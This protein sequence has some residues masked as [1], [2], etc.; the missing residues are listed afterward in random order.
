MGDTSPN[1]RSALQFFNSLDRSRH[2]PLIPRRNA[3]NF[4][5][6]LKLIVD[7]ATVTSSSY[8]VKKFIPRA[9]LIKV[10]EFVKNKFKSISSQDYTKLPDGDVRE[11]TGVKP[12]VPPRPSKLR[13]QPD[14][15]QVVG[16]SSDNQLLDGY[17]DPKDQLTP[18]IEAKQ[19]FEAFKKEVSPYNTFEIPVDALDSDFFKQTLTI[20]GPTA[21]TGK[22]IRTSSVKSQTSTYRIPDQVKRSDAFLEPYLQGLSDRHSP[23][24]IAAPSPSP[25]LCRGAIPHPVASL[26]G[27]VSRESL[28]SSH[29]GGSDASSEGSEE[30]YGATCDIS[31]M[32]RLV[33]SHPIWFLPGIQRAGAFHLLQGKEEGCF[34]VRKSSQS[35]TMAL[36]VRLPPDKGPY[37]EHYLIHSS[38]GRLGLETSENRFVD[39]AALIAHYSS[40]CDELPVQLALPKTIRESKSRQQLSSLA[41]LGQEFWRY[42]PPPSTASSPDADL[43]LNLNPLMTTFKQAEPSTPMQSKPARPNTL[44]LLNKNDPKSEI[45]R[46]M[47]SLKGELVSKT[48]PPPPPRWSKPSTPQQNNFTVT[49]TVTFSVNSQSPNNEKP[50]PSKSEAEA[51]QGDSK[52]ISPQGQ[53]NSTISSRGGIRHQVMSPNSV[54]SPSS[55]VLSPDTLS[56]LSVSKGTRQSKRTKQKISKHYQESDIVDSPTMHYYKSGLGD[57]ISDYEDVWTNEG[58]LINAKNANPN[59]ASPD[60]LQHTPAN[61]TTRHIVSLNNN[62][63]SPTDSS[64]NGSSHRSVCSTPIQNNLNKASLVQLPLADTN[65]SQQASELPSPHTPKQ[66]SPFYAEP[67]DSLSSINQIPNIPRRQIARPAPG[68]PTQHRH[69]NPPALSSAKVLSTG[70]ERVDDSGMMSSSVDNLSPK[71]RFMGL[72]KPEVKPV[73]PPLIRPMINNNESWQID[74]SWKFVTADCDIPQE[75]TEP[76]YDSDWPTIPNLLTSLETCTPDPDER[77]TLQDLISKRFPDIR[78]SALGMEDDR[79]RISAYDNVEDRRPPRAPP[80]EISELTEFSE[81]WAEIC[82]GTTETDESY[83]ENLTPTSIKVSSLNK[84]K[85]F[86][87]RLDPLLSAPRVEALRNREP[88]GPKTVGLAIRTYAL[89]LAQDKS[90]TFAQ[91]V[92]NFIACTC[93]SKETNPQVVMRNMRQFMN[94]MKNYL[95]KHGEKGFYKEIE[96]ERN[97]LKSTEFLNLDSILEGVMHKL[98]VKPLRNHLQKLFLDHYTKTGAIKL[99]ADNIQYASTRPIHELAIKAKLALPPENVLNKIS[100]YLHKLQQADSPLEKLE[101]LLAAIALIFNTVKSNHQIGSGRSFHLGADDFL[102]LFVWVLVKTNFVAAEIESEYMWGLLHP[103]LLSGEGGYYLTTLSSAV[104]VLKNFKEGCQENVN[105]HVKNESV[106]K[107]VVPD[108]LHGSILTKTLPARPHMTTKEVCKIIAHKARIT[109]PQDY[110]L[111]RL[112]DGEETILL[113]NECPQDFIKEGRHTM[114]A[115]KRIDAKI[116]WPTQDK[117][118]I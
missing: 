105:S 1:F 13:L 38:E 32:E 63:L 61:D 27:S 49:T 33:L 19:I 87:D 40:C 22:S 55:D 111:Y 112:T 14:V 30:G 114:L 70:L 15:V 69:S 57:K 45:T 72:R 82:Q 78:A 76:D 12:K 95:V 84:S 46:S 115:Y 67:A 90:T 51:T 89:E 42:S 103:S 21:D 68:I 47:S 71:Q 52:R 107:V 118:N 16:N 23:P 65:A 7:N 66:Q 62:V 86:R 39:M 108:E 117:L 60:L 96:R 77:T 48:P 11:Q 83:S 34:V 64:H 99:L 2:S 92:D 102:P 3:S 28:V 56:P 94:G 91:N 37:I 74:N 116:A 26:S 54:L 80:S 25:P 101:Y 73:Q 98:V 10:D 106:L 100:Q 43:V 8:N 81:P 41:L 93:E 53:S 59:F 88:G 75:S 31:L 24:D 44:N 113:D 6:N 50:L 110:A 109:N 5:V 58:N 85:S 97:K 9:K 18:D 4:E 104:H 29:G 79:C 35:D 17:R 20:V 36:S